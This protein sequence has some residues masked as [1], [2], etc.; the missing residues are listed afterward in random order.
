MNIKHPGLPFFLLP[1]FLLSGVALQAAGLYLCL[2]V[3]MFV[4]GDKLAVAPRRA[5][6]STASIF[7]V[8]YLLPIVFQSLLGL[9]ENPLRS[10]VVDPPRVL[11]CELTLKAWLK[12]PISTATVGLGIGWAFFVLTRG[13]PRHLGQQAD[14]SALNVVSDDSVR[15]TAFSRGLLIS[16]ALL[17]AYCLYQHLTGY[18]L[19]LKSRLLAPEHQMANGSYRTF[20]FY[21][22]PLSLAGASL[23]W[24]SFGLWGGW[25]EFRK[26]SLASG[27]SLP[28]WFLVSIFHLCLIYMSG[29][30][31]A[32][33]VAVLMI[34]VLLAAVTLSILLVRVSPQSPVKQSQKL[35]KL[36]LPFS[37]GLLVLL[38]SLPFVFSSEFFKRILSYFHVRGTTSGTMGHGLF[39]DRELFWQVYLAMWRDAPFLGQGEFAVRHGVRTQYYLQEGFA[40]LRDKFGAHNI[41]LE[42]LGTMG[43]VGF[44][45][46]L[47]LC[48][49]LFLNLKILAGRSQQRLFVLRALLLAFIANLLHGLTQNTFFDSAV[50]ACYLAIVGIFVVPPLTRTVELKSVE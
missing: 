33:A 23:V 5:V 35:K 11:T 13:S 31:T 16:S 44:F 17:F 21:G 36:L 34:G 37:M 48:V 50:S 32:L 4:V 28:L 24:L 26:R 39:G 47:V 42:V 9:F 8:S 46:Y 19:L 2:V 20:G 40:D 3:W 10:C 30:R 7:I 6:L 25:S 1:F 38:G 45:A 22:H 49:L 27:L 14:L 15:V 18:S 43:V 29:G 12:S 41:F